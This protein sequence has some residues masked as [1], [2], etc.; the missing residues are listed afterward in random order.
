MN[1]LTDNPDTNSRHFWLRGEQPRRVIE[2]DEEI[3]AWQVYGHAEAL[4]ILSDPKTYSSDLM[5]LFADADMADSGQTVE[6]MMA[7]NLVQMD[8]PDHRKLRSLVSSAFTPKVVADLK[9]RIAALTHELLDRAG[10]GR[11]ELVAD[12]AYPLPVTVIAELLG[13]P[14]SDHEQFRDWARSMGENKNE[15]SLTGMTD[16]QKHDMQVQMDAARRMG[17][18]IA[19]HA[20]D[21]RRHPREDLLTK[22]VEAE[23]DGERLSDT[24]VMNFA[25]LLLLAGHITTTLL[26]GNTTLCLDANPA[27]AARVRADRSLVPTAIEESLRLLTPFAMLGR[28]TTTEVTI[29]G[30]RI[31]AD[32]ALFV[33]VGAANRD[34][35][36]FTDPNAF[37][38]AR[39]PN[40]HIAFGRGIHFCLG[41]PLARLEGRIV[42]NILLDRYPELCTDPANPPT[43]LR[44]WDMTGVS[45][46]PL[47]V[48]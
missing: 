7:G 8:P 17:E 10:T 25:S 16:E 3:G 41:A 13:V 1:I 45:T 33:W 19:G 6:E 2:F 9:P 11:I 24:E 14:A 48:G 20:A 12:L 29:A 42:L 34:A 21:R 18:Y 27:Q 32:Q 40:P 23:V 4:R 26:I 38:P 30:Q 36:V 39:D 22:L 37:D 15:I 28:R 44:A 31:P 5:R 47:L 35:R 43:F 46:L